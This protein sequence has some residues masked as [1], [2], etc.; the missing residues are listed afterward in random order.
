MLTFRTVQIN[1][2]RMPKAG[3]CW[4]HSVINTRCSWLHADERGFRSRH[5]RL[6]SSGDYRNPP[7][8]SEHAGLRKWMKEHSGQRIEIPSELRPV[9]GTT[10]L[11]FFREKQVKLLALSVGE[12]HAHMQIQLIDNIVAIRRIIG[13]AKRESSRSVKKQMPGSVWGA[14]GEHKRIENRSH[15][16]NVFGLHPVQTRTRSMDLVVQGF[17]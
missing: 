5:H 13:H 16:E 15:H 10:L 2:P 6:H 3:H 12:I 14:G 8:K 11:Q 4:R 9:I 17:E 1:T 7:P